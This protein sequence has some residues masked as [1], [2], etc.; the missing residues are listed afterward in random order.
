[1]S[2]NNDTYLHEQLA[3]LLN[4]LVRVLSLSLLFRLD[5]NVQIHLSLLGLETGVELVGRAWFRLGI[6]GLRNQHF[7]LDEDA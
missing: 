1:M 6:L 2:E 7:G 4:G 5:T 3:V